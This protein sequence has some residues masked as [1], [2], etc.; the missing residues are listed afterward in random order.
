VIAQV[1]ARRQTHAEERLA[2]LERTLERTVDP[3]LMEKRWWRVERKRAQV[4][5]LQRRQTAIVRWL[6]PS[7]PVPAAHV[8]TMHYEVAA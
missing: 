8:P 6:N 3:A 7:A 4:E 1:L 2:A 5:H